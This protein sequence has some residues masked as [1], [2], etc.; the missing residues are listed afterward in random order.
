MEAVRELLLH[1]DCHRS[2]GPDGLHPRVLRELAG[3]IAE[4]LS[5]IYQR[6]WMTREV[7]EDWRLADATPIYRKG[8]KEDLGNYRPISLTSVPGK[9]MEQI[10]LGEIT[11]S[12]SDCSESPGEQ[13]SAEA[14]HG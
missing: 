14:W 4:P 9:V 10:I 6:S 2:M 7:P 11:L 13:Y 1:L 12:L 8:H 3:A 5:A